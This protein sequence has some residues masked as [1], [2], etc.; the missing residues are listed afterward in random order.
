M[1]IVF[2]NE[3]NYAKLKQDDYSETVKKFVKATFGQKMLDL[4]EIDMESAV[5][6]VGSFIY[7]KQMI[8]TVLDNDD[9]DSADKLQSKQKILDVHY[10]SYKF[11]IE[12]L[13]QLINEPSMILLVI[14]YT[15]VT[16]MHR[17]H[18]KQNTNR[19]KE[20]YYEAIELMINNSSHK[21]KIADYLKH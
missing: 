17:I 4:F 14:Y 11:S 19:Y 6:F 3:T 10:F 7:P 12:R 9:E 13:Q 16:Q 5:F 20:A 1:T 2:N 15:I 21:A 8:A 18:I